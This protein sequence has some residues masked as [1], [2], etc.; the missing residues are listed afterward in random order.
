M[1]SGSKSMAIQ[2]AKLNIKSRLETIAQLIRD[3][4]VTENDS[5]IIRLRAEIEIHKQ[6]LET[7]RNL[8]IDNITIFY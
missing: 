8:T 5:T 7:A 6:N 3:F 2:M 1:M 4:G